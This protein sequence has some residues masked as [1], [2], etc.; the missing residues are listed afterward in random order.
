MK[1]RT[2]LLRLTLSYFLTILLIILLISAVITAIFS[3]QIKENAV[4]QM[5]VRISR[6][7]GDIEEQLLQIIRGCDE[8]KNNPYII[9]LLTGVAMEEK[10]RMPF[11][12]IM[13]RVSPGPG[14]SAGWSLS[15]ETWKFWMVYTEG[16]CIAKPFFKVRISHDSLPAIMSTIFHRPKPFPKPC[17]MATGISLI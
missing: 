13:P 6:I 12:R 11:L 1:S 14:W 16:S 8:V 15:I 17:L 4:N 10:T 5:D 9:K 3:S 2:I 7:S